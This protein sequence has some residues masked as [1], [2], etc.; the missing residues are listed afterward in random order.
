MENMEKKQNIEQVDTNTC[1]DVKLPS[2]LVLPM[3]EN[4]ILAGCDM[5]PTFGYNGDLFYMGKSDF[6]GIMTNPH[7]CQRCFRRNSEIFFRNFENVTGCG[8]VF[9]ETILTDKYI[10][11]K[12]LEEN[13]EA[14]QNLNLPVPYLSNGEYHHGWYFKLLKNLVKL[15]KTNWSSKLVET[16]FLNPGEKE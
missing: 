16:E 5:C 14:V 9:I 1:F 13:C 7:L 10:D 12:T 15:A 4:S 2:N 8:V 6:T 3:R 11:E